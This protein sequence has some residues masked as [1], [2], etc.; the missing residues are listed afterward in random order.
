MTREK[1]EKT[2][3]CLWTVRNVKY[4]KLYRKNMDLD[5]RFG[6]AMRLSDYCISLGI[7][8]TIN[9]SSSMM[10]SNIMKTLN[11]YVCAE[12]LLQIKRYGDKGSRNNISINLVLYIRTFVIYGN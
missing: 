11:G 6:F 3:L 10:F 5:E 1:K 2:K 8:I 12:W 4:F 9:A 7:P